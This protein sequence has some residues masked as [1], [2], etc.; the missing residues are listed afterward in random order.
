M[1]NTGKTIIGNKQAGFNFH[2]EDEYTAGIMLAGWEVKA[3]L[4]KKANLENAFIH[5]K[6]GEVFLVNAHFSP[7]VNVAQ[8]IK[9][10][11]TR[12]R[13]LLLNRKEID[14]LIGKVEAKGYTLVPLRIFFGD[15]R[16]KLQLALAKGKKQHDKREAEKE[17]DWKREQGQLLKQATR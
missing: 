12:T 8:H 13:K 15:R 17:R 2:L 1:S 5:I 11:P 10:D 14:T 9:A 7:A 3:L 16:I 4:A 6:D